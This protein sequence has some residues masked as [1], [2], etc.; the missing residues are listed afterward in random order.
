MNSKERKYSC[1]LIK[2]LSTENYPFTGMSS[3][4][5]NKQKIISKGYNNNFKSAKKY[6]LSSSNGTLDYDSKEQQL[7]N[8]SGCPESARLSTETNRMLNVQSLIKKLKE[9]KKIIIDMKGRIALNEKEF[10]K[11]QHE[12]NL[13]NIQYGSLK[14]KNDELQKLN[15]TRD[16]DI[17]KLEKENKLLIKYNF[18]IY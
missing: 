9:S 2:S 7:E 8:Y 11:L 6:S 1:S 4:L 13:I 5:L 18:I 16:E 10:A 3:Q 12:L 17:I 15:K 14:E